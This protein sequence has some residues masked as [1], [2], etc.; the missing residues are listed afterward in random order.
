ME[1]K[2]G[3]SLRDR[4]LSFVYAIRG[5]RRLVVGERNALIHAALTIIVIAVAA[6]LQV[7]ADDWCWLIAAIGLVWICE[8]FNT[9]IECLGDAVT[10]QEHPIIRDAKDLAAGAVLLAAITAGFIGVMRLTPY[11][12]Q[13]VF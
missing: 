4:M 6:L 10:S 1:Q 7:S 13:L 11:L 2:P 8:A 9:A 5:L 3:F 12:I